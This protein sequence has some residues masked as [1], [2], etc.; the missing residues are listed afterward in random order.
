MKLFYSL[1]VGLVCLLGCTRHEQS[2]K[3]DSLEEVGSKVFATGVMIGWACR[4]HGG[5]TN[6]AQM[7]I[8]S[9]RQDNPKLAEQWFKDHVQP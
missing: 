9:W 6:D 8:D 4:D 3:R 1:S 2:P 5:T 7:I